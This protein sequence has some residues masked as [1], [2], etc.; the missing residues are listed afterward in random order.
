MSGSMP[1][2]LRFAQRELRT[3]LKGFRI[4]L[5]CLALGVAAIAAVG[6]VST[7][8]LTGLHADARILLGGDVELRLTHRTASPEAVAH[9]AASGR[10]STLTAMRA[11]GRRV[12]GEERSLVELKA[13]D[14]AYP[15]V[16]AIGLEPAIDLDAAL[17]RRDGVYG[18]VAEDGLAQRLNITIGDRLLLGD[19]TLELRALIRDEPDRLVNFASFGPRLMVADDV[20][21]STGL[22]QVGSLIRYYYRLALPPGADH[23][24]WLEDL[25]DRFPD[26]GWRARSIDN[27]TPGY[28]T[29]VDR[30]T[31]FLT[32]VGLTALLVGGVGVAMAVKSYLDGKTETVATLKCLGAPAALVFRTYLAVVMVLAGVGTVIGLV[33]GAG[34]PWLA[35]IVANPLLPFELP[36]GLYPA[37][38]AL[39]ALYGLLTALAFSLWPLGK[40]GRIKA[41]QLFR[42]AVVPL[43]GRPALPYVIATAAAVG[44]LAM[45]AIWGSADRA[46]A[47][48]F[49]V[50]ALGSVILFLAAAAAIMWLA[51]RVGRPRTP[52]LRL[53]LANLHRPG[54]PTPGVVLALGLGLTVLVTIALIQSNLSRQVEERIPKAAP[55]FFFI[56]IQPHQ[57]ADFRAILDRIGGET[58]AVGDIRTTPIIRGRITAVDGTSADQINAKGSAWALRGDRGLTYAASPPENTA[59]VAGSWWPEDYAGPPLISFDEHI[60]GD[61][62]VGVGDT[63]TL[64]ILGRPITARIANLRKIDWGSLG[65]NFTFI[66]APGTLEAAP[67]SVIA[68]VYLDDPA[69]EARVQRAITDALPNVTAIRVS[70]ALEAAN[71]ILSAVSVAVRGTAAVTLIAGT[72]VLAGAVAAGHTRRVRDS[73]ILKVLGATRVRIIRIY[74][75]EYG[76]LGL[77]T[78]MIAAVIGSIAAW[79]VV[80]YVMRGDFVLAGEVVA[81]TTALATAITLVF[82][83]VGTW[84]ALGQRPGPM[85]RNE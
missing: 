22:V 84:H 38:L 60:A 21:P 35:A 41:A 16:G 66:F 34:A 10:L 30:V 43:G 31:L 4:F 79:V 53:A 68:T 29:F 33:V 18:A 82:G 55:A 47:A 8:M 14:D 36:T 32:L 64:N 23:R 63:I 9:M 56:D 45:L 39:A 62:G 78:A 1:L 27:A 81:S 69:L 74:L 59:I 44:S 25:A 20:L 80:T 28:D 26:A 40:I 73:V 6:S 72:L 5:A 13:V 12:D 19:A 61:L 50:G 7:A 75:M 71:R 67:H 37:P 49:V 57:E 70:D 17:E 2:S 24:A 15:L 77:A 48:W 52:E 3:G 85:L 76:L 83:F 65:M 11:M 58:G 42:A 51:R 46:F 54:A